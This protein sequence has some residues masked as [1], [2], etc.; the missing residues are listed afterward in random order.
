[1]GFSYALCSEVFSGAIEET[2]RQVAAIGFDGIEIAPFT[3]ADSVDDISA[4]R[5]KEIRKIC[6]GEGLK[7]VGLHW[8][9][10][11]PK[12]LHITTPD[13]GLRLRS[14][15]YLESL[16]RFCR[17]LGGGMMVLGSPMQR[18]VVDGDDAA[19]AKKRAAEGLRGVAEV[20]G[21]CGVE[22]LLEPLHPQETNFLQTVEDALDLASEIDHPQVGYILDC[23]A[24]S[25][26]P[27][28]IVA[29][30]EKYG[31]AAGHFHANEPNGMGPGMGGTLDFAPIL[32]A[33]KGTGYRG[34]VS[35]EPFD[36]KPDSDTVARKALETLR[37]AA[38]AGD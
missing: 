30:I 26:M 34:W 33:L 11:S 4:E 19:S 10:V 8:L 1:M 15:K 9:L 32:G 6:E 25:G 28:G 35:T 20:C 14:L 21:E 24:M 37:Q 29:T 36:Y 27:R 18:N 38:A 5:R 17:D 12:G 16:T 13:D 22:L 7:M 3:I 2:V 23:K 31:K